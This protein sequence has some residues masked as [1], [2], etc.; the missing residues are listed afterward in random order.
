M[1]K[2][3]WLGLVFGAFTVS[4]C[5]YL[6]KKALNTYLNQFQDKKAEQVCFEKLPPAYKKQ[7]HS[8]LD[9]L[10]WNDSLETSISYFSSCSKA[11]KSLESFQASAYPLRYKR[12]QFSQADDSL[13]SVLEVSQPQ[14]NKTYMA[15]YTTQK[16]HCY[17][18]I[19]LVA[20]S[21]SSFEKEEPLF[22]KFIKSFNYK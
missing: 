22:K 21:L 3:F 15:I 5:S 7:A 14:N 1:V 16:K 6:K 4:G 2:I 19:N 9:A 13:Y 12:V 17:F 11:P 20:G 10:W 8:T 18:N